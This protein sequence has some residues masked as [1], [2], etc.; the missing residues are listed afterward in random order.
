M[1]RIRRKKRIRAKILGVSTR[2]RLCVFRSSRFLYAQV[3]D[4][5]SGKTLVAASTKQSKLKNDI[6]GSKKLGKIIAEKCSK[7]KIKEVNFDRSGYKYHG[8]IK[9]L[10]EGAREGGLKF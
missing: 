2:P 7:T 5:L 6:E 4:D 10:A 3:I 9:A 1:D 8:K